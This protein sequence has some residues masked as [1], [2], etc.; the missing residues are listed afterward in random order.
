ME[1]GMARALAGVALVVASVWWAPVAQEPV[2][3][4]E[5]RPPAAPAGAAPLPPVEVTWVEPVPRADLPLRFTQKDPIEGFWRLHRRSVDGQ[6]ADP[7]IGYLA[8]GRRH[9]MV[10]IQAA[11]PNPDMPL[12]RSTTYSWRRVDDRDTVHLS[13]LVGHFNDT[14]GDVHVATAGTGESRRFVLL[15]ASLRIE[16]GHGDWLEFVRIE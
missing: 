16:R 4:Q 15:D 12:L 3:T 13:V 5:P 10:Q 7:G 14:D 9:L 8:I 1:H 11:G 2:K 6:G